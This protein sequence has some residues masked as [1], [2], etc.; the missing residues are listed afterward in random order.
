[1]GENVL[2]GISAAIAAIPEEPP[3]LLAVVLGLGAYRLLRRGVLVRRLNAEET[4]G[5]VD[6]I[7]TDK[8]G[9]LTQNRLAVASLA[10]PEGPVDEPGDRR[11]VLA[12]AVRA[13]EGSWRHAEGQPAGAFVRALLAAA[14]AEGAEVGLDHSL[15]DSATPPTDAEPFSRV[16]W[17][18]P[19][20][21][22]PYL[23]PLAE[24]FRATPLALDDWVLVLIVS[25]VPAVVAQLLRGWRRV[26]WVA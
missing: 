12:D 18:A 9:T 7:I 6:L 13:D 19:G 8:T 10:T 4:L 15:L 24:A 11:S 23:P 20:G 21:A 3:V 5:A 26:T 2:A 1:M 16:R 14:A 22:I 17:H 25:L